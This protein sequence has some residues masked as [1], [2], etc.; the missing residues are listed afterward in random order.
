VK[1]APYFCSTESFGC[2]EVTLAPGSLSGRFRVVWLLCLSAA[3][4]VSAP[5]EMEPARR[6]GQKY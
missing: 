5:N 1:Y 3:F 4:L 6:S 2:V